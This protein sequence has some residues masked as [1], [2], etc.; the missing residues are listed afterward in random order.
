MLHSQMMQSMPAKELRYWLAFYHSQ[1][2]P[3]KE[4]TPE[5]MLAMV[6]ALGGLNATR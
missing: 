3:A 2:T 1:L 5:Q 4:Q 6:D